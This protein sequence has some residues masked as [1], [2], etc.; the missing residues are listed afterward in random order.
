LSSVSRVSGKRTEI[1]VEEGRRLG[2]RT[3]RAFDQSTYS[4]E[5]WVAQKSR[6]SCP[7]LK[8]GIRFKARLGFLILP[9]LLPIHVA[10][11]EETGTMKHGQDVHGSGAHQIHDAIGSYDEF[12][13]IVA[14]KLGND[15]TGLGE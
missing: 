1:A 6:S 3:T 15:A 4:V 2:K 12:S 5:S 14:L 13:N 7:V 9:A 8:T 10:G 11:G